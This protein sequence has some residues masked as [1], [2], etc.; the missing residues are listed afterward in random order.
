[1]A[2]TEV[3]QTWRMQLLLLWPLNCL[4]LTKII[5]VAVLLCER[6]SLWLCAGATELVCSCWNFHWRFS[7]GM[8][9]TNGD[10]MLQDKHS[11]SSSWSSGRSWRMFLDTFIY[12]GNRNYIRP[13]IYLD[14]SQFEH[15]LPIGMQNSKFQFFNISIRTESSQGATVFV[16]PAW[17]PTV[18]SWGEGS[19]PYGQYPWT[20]KTPGLH[21][22]TNTNAT[23][24]M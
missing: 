11:A 23:I 19:R 21:T 8:T 16:L 7:T 2:W 1:M 14:S 3:P 20:L 22:N 24:L 9:P 6:H 15:L 5:I 18:Y 17:T 4:L 12:F 13:S 10:F